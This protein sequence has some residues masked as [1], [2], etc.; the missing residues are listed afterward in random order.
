MLRK[1]SFADTARAAD[2][3]IS[4]EKSFEIKEIPIPFVPGCVNCLS[5]HIK[6]CRLAKEDKD[7]VV[8]SLPEQTRDLLETEVQLAR[9]DV[10]LIQRQAFL[11]VERLQKDIDFTP[12]EIDAL[13][14][15]RTPEALTEAASLIESVGD[16]GLIHLL[17][18]KNE[19]LRRCK[20]ALSG[21]GNTVTMKIQTTVPHTNLGYEIEVPKTGETLG[22]S[23]L[24]CHCSAARFLAGKSNKDMYRREKPITVMAKVD[25]EDF[26]GFIV[27]TGLTVIAMSLIKTLTMYADSIFRMTKVEKNIIG[28]GLFSKLN[29]PARFASAIRAVKKE[30]WD[31]IPIGFFN[32]M[33]SW[34]GTRSLFSFSDI[35]KAGQKILQTVYQRTKGDSTIS[36]WIEEFKIAVKQYEIRSIQEIPKSIIEQLAKKFGFDPKEFVNLYLWAENED[37]GDFEQ[38]TAQQNSYHKQEAEIVLYIDSL[39]ML[40]MHTF[41][42]MDLLSTKVITNRKELELQLEK[43]FSDKLKLMFGKWGKNIISST[44][45]D[46]LVDLRAMLESYDVQAKSAKDKSLLKIS[47]ISEFAARALIMA[48]RATLKDL[49]KLKPKESAASFLGRINGLPAREDWIKMPESL[50]RGKGMPFFK[51]WVTKLLK[52]TK[53]APLD[54]KIKGLLEEKI[55]EKNFLDYLSIK[56]RSKPDR[57]APAKDNTP[58]RKSEKKRGPK[59]DKSK[60]PSD[61]KPKGDFSCFNCGKK[62]HKA[63]SCRKNKKK[64]ESGGGVEAL[65]KILGVGK[66]K[67]TPEQSPGILEL[68][69]LIAKLQ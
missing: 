62:G 38:Y 44:V 46:S 35:P 51:K 50:F 69:T 30:W 65:L 41:S 5:K 48:K 56:K 42:I 29:L 49:A 33:Q 22:K 14:E 23:I 9:E 12:K 36:R 59:A 63:D 40:P 34:L 26:G 8:I 15:K 55:T 61:S 7:R 25:D 53:G 66:K 18:R 64:E 3:V 16:S 10:L 67:P 37:T 1:S 19:I 4:D 54:A 45:I 47:S 52:T 39:L 24:L 60:A 13:I 57:S 58:P 43:H 28:S 17:Q 31:Q 68:L 6:M 27:A 2:S 21:E 11:D 20:N 32:I